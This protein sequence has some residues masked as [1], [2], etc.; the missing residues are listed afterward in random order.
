MSAGQAEAIK[1]TPPAGNGSGDVGA[2][3]T[4]P[5]VVGSTTGVAVNSVTALPP[6]LAGQWYT[7]IVTANAHIRFDDAAVGAA[8]ATDYLMVANVEY[9]W[10][11]D[12]SSAFFS[13]IRDTADGV[14][15]RYQSNK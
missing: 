14:L 15:Y 5:V 11:I 12:N 7:F 2:C 8:I 6:F 3:M 9:D 1:K 10:F 13:I 4:T